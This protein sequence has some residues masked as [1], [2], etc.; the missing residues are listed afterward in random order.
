MMEL[1]LGL[2]DFCLFLWYSHPG[3]NNVEFYSEKE[4]NTYSFYMLDLVSQ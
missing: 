3:S 2:P 1:M 4:N